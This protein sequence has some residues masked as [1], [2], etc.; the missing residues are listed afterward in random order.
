[1]IEIIDQE[2]SKQLNLIQKFTEELHF[3]EVCQFELNE[4][5]ENIPWEILINSGIYLLEVKNSNNYSNFEEWLANFKM[6]WEHEDYL[7]KFTPNFKLKRIKAHNELKDW[8]PLYIGKSK[9]MKSRLYDHIYKD[10]NKTTFAMKL[11]AREN[12]KNEIFKISVINL[13]LKNYNTI[14]P[15]IENELRNRINPLIG[16]Q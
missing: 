13:G 3:Q 11:L 7:R 12:M 9:N 4:K 1:M 2:I 10:I 6:R 14:I 8:I 15:L 16:K 5:L